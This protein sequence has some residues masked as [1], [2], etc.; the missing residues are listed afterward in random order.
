MGLEYAR[1]YMHPVSVV[2]QRIFLVNLF[3][4]QSKNGL[5]IGQTREIV[6]DKVVDGVHGN[7]IDLIRETGSIVTY[8]EEF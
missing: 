8:S 4:R 2:H 5:L 3:L 7:G 6:R 1:L